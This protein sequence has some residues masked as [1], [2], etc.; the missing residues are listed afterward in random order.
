MTDM[1][2]KRSLLQEDLLFQLLCYINYFSERL[3]FSVSFCGCWPFCFTDSSALNFH[4]LRSANK[5][6]VPFNY[7][8]F[9][10][11]A[12]SLFSIRIGWILDV[13]C[14]LNVLLLS[15]SPCSPRFPPPVVSCF[16]LIPGRK[17]FQ[18]MSVALISSI[19][20]GGMGVR[21]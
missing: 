2:A 12:V 19:Y 8:F 13:L 1:W 21:L 5:V 20:Y 6:L 4:W 15:P 10:T 16:P 17:C 11:W 14:F 3:I 7:N 18:M 9:T